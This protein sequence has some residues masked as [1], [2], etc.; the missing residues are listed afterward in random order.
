MD[1][2]R[3]R[4]EAS[5]AGG[6]IAISE[7]AKGLLE[8]FFGKDFSEEDFVGEDTGLLKDGRD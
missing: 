3:C 2:C 8:D 7:E 6:R 1:P 5:A 4:A